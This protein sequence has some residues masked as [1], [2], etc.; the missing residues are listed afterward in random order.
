MAFDW[1][2]VLAEL[3]S[4]LCFI[5]FVNMVSFSLRGITFGPLLL[6]ARKRKKTRRY[7]LCDLVALMVM[8]QLAAG[9]ALALARRPGVQVHNL[10]WNPPLDQYATA[11]VI[12]V[13]LALMLWWWFDGSQMLNAA[14]VKSGWTRF[15]F[16][17]FWT[18]FSYLSTWLIFFGG[19]GVIATIAS[20]RS[21]VR[22]TDVTL[23]IDSIAYIGFF[24]FGCL[25]VGIFGVIAA[26]WW[27]NRLADASFTDRMTNFR[28]QLKTL[29]RERAAA[30]ADSEVAVEDEPVESEHDDRQVVENSAATADAPASDRP[31]DRLGSQPDSETSPGE[32]PQ[33]AADDSGK[34]PIPERAGDQVQDREE[35]SKSGAEKSRKNRSEN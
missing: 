28:A 15:V 33:V 14:D 7:P 23:R 24:S 6:E 26:R 30:N 19:C 8:L 3:P 12:I 31:H 32:K 35:G 10:A 4:L 13:A 29:E 2:R 17:A 16:L 20:R 22:W 21:G 9:G 25:A 11:S 18:P 5:C 34:P 1:G 27:S